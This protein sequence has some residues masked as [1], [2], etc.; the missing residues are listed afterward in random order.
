MPV[1]YLLVLAVFVVA[2]GKN[3]YLLGLL[4][5]LA[6]AGAVVLAGAGRRAGVR[7]F[8]VCVAVTALFP[9]PALLPVLP[10][11]TFARLVLPRAQRGRPG[12]DRLAGGRGA[13]A[14]R[15]RRA[16][17]RRTA[18]GGHRDAELRRGRCTAVVRR[19]PPVYSGHNGFGDW[20]P[21]PGSGPVVC[22]G[23]SA[24][25][26]D[27]LAGCARAAPLHTG[28]DNEEDGNGVWVCD[29]PVGSWAQAW[30][31]LRHLSA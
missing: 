9:L 30:Q 13:G 14:R 2:G 18:Y 10:A 5:P 20:G 31:R 27:A 4:P 23:F 12:D 21:P 7:A 19:E 25:D 28:V 16:A 24:P 17:G 26:P 6:A 1:A 3:Y 8:T 22:V 29:G 15:R 11:Q